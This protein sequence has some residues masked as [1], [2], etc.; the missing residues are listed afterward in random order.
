MLPKNISEKLLFSLLFHPHL[1]H[2]SILLGDCRGHDFHKGENLFSCSIELR[3]I[4]G[5][6]S[7]HVHLLA[8]G[9]FKRYSFCKK[10][11]FFFFFFFLGPYPGHMEVPRPG[12]ELEL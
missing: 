8:L 7:F 10:K 5:F 6:S 2:I 3:V 11:I 12:V 4:T 1:H 9:G